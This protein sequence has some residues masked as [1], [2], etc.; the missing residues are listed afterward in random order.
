MTIS[1][2]YIRR[3]VSASTLSFITLAFAPSV[4]AQTTTILAVTP[5]PSAPATHIEVFGTHFVV[6]ATGPSAV[7]L[8]GYNATFTVASDGVTNDQLTIEIPAEVLA[9][10]AGTYQLKVSQSAAAGRTAIF[11]VGLPAIGPAG[12]QGDPG[13]SG[14]QGPAGPQGL[15]APQTLP[16]VDTLQISAAAGYGGA[17]DFTTDCPVG[18]VATGMNVGYLVNSAIATFQM[19]CRAISLALSVATGLTSELDTTVTTTATAGGLMIP[20]AT[21]TL[22]CPAGMVVNGVTGARISFVMQA[23]RL[24]CRQPLG[25][26]GTGTSPALEIRSGSSAFDVSCPAGSVAT[27]FGAEGSG[28]AVRTLYLRCR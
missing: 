5:A 15:P 3:A 18:S 20:N 19:R 13:P 1:Y 24:S 22:D 25:G 28:G 7:T 14:A 11:E 12:P 10:G 27:G 6:N 2:R 9:A 8:G 4:F 26:A 17:S 23:F 16:I 21:S